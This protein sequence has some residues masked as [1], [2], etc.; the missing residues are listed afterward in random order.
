MASNVGAKLITGDALPGF[1]VAV[2][3]LFGVGFGYERGTIGPRKAWKGRE[4]REKESP[5][6]AFRVFRGLS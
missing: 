4:R 6:Y 2:A 1:S 3:S 5:G